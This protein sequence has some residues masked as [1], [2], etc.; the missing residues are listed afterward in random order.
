M[1][2]GLL[3]PAASVKKRNVPGQRAES[4]SGAARPAEPDLSAWPERPA[5][6]GASAGKKPKQLSASGLNR[7]ARKIM[8]REWASAKGTLGNGQQKYRLARLE[9]EAAEY[10]RD[11]EREKTLEAHAQMRAAHL[12][13]SLRRALAAFSL[14]LREL[15]LEDRGASAEQLLRRAL[16]PVGDVDH[17]HWG[18]QGCEMVLEPWEERRQRRRNR[19]SRPVL[20]RAC[21]DDLLRVT[22]C[23]RLDGE[24][25][26]ASRR[27][28]IVDRILEALHRHGRTQ[29]AL[30]NAL[31]RIGRTVRRLTGDDGCTKVSVEPWE[32]VRRRRI[33]QEGRPI[34]AYVISAD[35]ALESIRCQPCSSRRRPSSEVRLQTTETL[36]K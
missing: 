30:R 13:E 10:K 19:A 31:D 12:M 23:T 21:V 27:E 26:E 8:A 34:K 36:Q 28:S 3:A 14:G 22:D 9:Q 16:G 1:T 20:F 35:S 18:P 5:I 29:E 33:E 2:D 7:I 32:E 15:P 6:S 24:Q 17:I 4:G 11:R 25:Y